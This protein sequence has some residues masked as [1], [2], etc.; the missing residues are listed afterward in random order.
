MKFEDLLMQQG[1]DKQTKL[2]LQKQVQRMEEE[3]DREVQVKR[4]LQCAIEGGPIDDDCCQTCSCLS[5]LLP[6]KLWKQKRNGGT[7]GLV[8]KAAFSCTMPVFPFVCDAY[9]LD[10]YAILPEPDINI[11][12]IGAY[13]NFI[14]ITRNTLDVS[15][16]SECLPD[17]RR[18][19]VLMQK[20]KRININYFTHK[21]KLAFWINVYNAS[22]MNAFLQH[23]LPSTE[24]KLLALMNE[25]RIDVGG[26]MFKASKIEQFILRH[27]ADIKHK[28]TNEN[29]MLL[30]HACGLSYPEPMV[31]FALCRGSWS[32]PALRYYTPDEVM[33]E[34]E[35]AKV[36]YL[37]ASIGITSRKKILVPK[38]MQWHMKDFADDMESLLEWIYSQLPYTSSLKR[39]IME[40]LNGQTQSPS[41][42]LVEIQPYAPEFRYLIPV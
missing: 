7:Q 32:S 13:K 16:L 25:A 40:C 12:D 28:S 11:R 26:F 10:P 6:F 30:R 14:Q 24:E 3:L 29:D 9:H 8:C 18:L 5:P 17:I 27:P 4:V 42:K 36:E 21:Q 20:L 33:N 15:R 1:E 37:E 35:K 22:V 23:G 2:Q 39:L 31:I 34:L 41:Q 19:R 38:L